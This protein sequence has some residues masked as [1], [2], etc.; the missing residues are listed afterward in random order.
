MR[1][2]R[3]FALWPRRADAAAAG[4]KDAA[5]ARAT[6]QWRAAARRWGRTLRHA[7]QL[8]DVYTDHSG[9]PRFVHLK[10]C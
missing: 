3:R 6:A 5:L 9:R 10:A 2:A 1:S 4:G 7:Y 8:T